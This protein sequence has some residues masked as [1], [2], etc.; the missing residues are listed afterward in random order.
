[1]Q[2]QRGR[3]HWLTKGQMRQKRAPHKSTGTL[4]VKETEVKKGYL[5][6]LKA[7]SSPTQLTPECSLCLLMCLWIIKYLKAS[8]VMSSKK[9]L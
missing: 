3:S 1:M 2:K 8:S 9:A 7:Q 5:L 6:I 4:I